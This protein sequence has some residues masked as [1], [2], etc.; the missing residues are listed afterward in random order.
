MVRH[1]LG[2]AVTKPLTDLKVQD[3]QFVRQIGPQEENRFRF[4]NP[5][6]GI[7]SRSD[8]YGVQVTILIIET[9]PVHTVVDIAGPDHPAEK[10]LE[11]VQGFVGFAGRDEARQGA[12]AVSIPDGLPLRDNVLDYIHTVGRWF[13][14][15]IAF[16]Q[17]RSSPQA[18]VDEIESESALIA[19]PWAVHIGIAAGGNAQQFMGPSAGVQQDIAAE[20]AMRA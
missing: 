12:G 13:Q 6:D 8:S 14:F 3:G 10:S 5:A 20:R 11:E 18:A 16:H 7:I 17:G 1:E 4:A 2:C 19:D 9:D 15:A